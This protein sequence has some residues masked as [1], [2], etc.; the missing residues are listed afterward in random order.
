MLKEDHLTEEEIAMCAEAI[1]SGRYALLEKSFRS[2]LEA[3]QQCGNEVLMV[4]E[5]N[6]QTETS[7][8]IIR[9]RKNKARIL[10]ALSSAA[11]LLLLMVVVFLHDNKL[12]DQQQLT[13]TVGDSLNKTDHE[14]FDDLQLNIPETKTADDRKSEKEAVKDESSGQKV[15]ITEQLAL[16]EP[17]PVL[18]NLYNNY[19]NSYR[20]S[21]FTYSGHG[22]IEYPDVMNIEWN[23][24]GNANL[25]IEI[26]N[27]K[28][29]KINTLTSSGN[30]VKIPDLSPGLYYFKII[31]EDFD[32]LYVGKIRI[33]ESVGK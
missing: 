8:I 6:R 33:K 4:S 16:Y 24:L 26:F 14:K 23:N 18:E 29:L 31:N 28:N 11:A 22:L 27:N 32:L 3:C 10:I 21:G 30:G 2:H 20:S 1:S 9:K 17:N 12:S 19:R 7:D 25:E 15:V 13:E 5:I